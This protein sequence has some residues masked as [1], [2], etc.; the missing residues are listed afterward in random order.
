[1]SPLRPAAQYCQHEMLLTL[2]GIGLVCVYDVHGGRRSES[3]SMIR[4]RG[5]LIL[6]SGLSTNSATKPERLERWA[7]N[8]I[9]QYQS[10]SCTTGVILGLYWGYIMIVENEMETT[11]YQPG[12]QRVWLS[13]MRVNAESLHTG[14]G[15]AQTP[16]RISQKT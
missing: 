9:V 8:L 5:V 4:S 16:A 12:S 10:A 14:R 1:M 13:G 15:C 11:M 3:L 6:G 2:T 7:E